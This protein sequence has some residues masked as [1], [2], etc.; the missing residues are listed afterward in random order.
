MKMIRLIWLIFKCYFFFFLSDITRNEKK[1]FFAGE[2]DSGKGQV[3]C[4]I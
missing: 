1:A 4:Y 3:N 2:D